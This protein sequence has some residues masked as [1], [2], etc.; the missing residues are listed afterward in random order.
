MALE[1]KALKSTG[2][3]SLLICLILIIGAVLRFYNY[4]DIPFTHDEFSAV[5]RTQFNSFHDLISKGVLVDTHPAGVQVFLY[6]WVKLFGIS[7]PLVKLP[8]TLFSL[9]SVYLLYA[10]GR[11]WFSSTAGLIASSF[12]AFLQYPVM[13]GQIARPYASGLFLVLLMVWFW[14]NLMLSPGKRFYLNLAGYILSSALCAY[15]HHFSLLFVGVA[16]LTGVFII[17]RN[18]RKAFILSWV[19]IFLLYSPHLTIFF[20]QLKQG[21]IG[22]WLSRPRPDFIFDYLA[23]AFQFSWY[24]LAL[25][26]LLVILALVWRPKARPRNDRMVLVS[27]IWFFVPLL[28]GF[29]YSFYINP[30][31][32]YSVLLFSFPFL[33]L[34]M[35]FYADAGKTW[36]KC[37]LVALTA[38]V[39]IPSLIM[40][41]RHYSIFYKS[42]YR[43]ILVESKN[44][45]EKLGR[46]NCF[47]LIDSHRRFTDYYL[48]KPGMERFTVNYIHDIF[49]PPVLESILDSC[50]S[51]YFVYGC[52]S[53]SAWEDYAMIHS[54]YPFVLS[55]TYFNEGDVYVFSKDSAGARADYYFSSYADFD[56]NSTGWENFRTARTWFTGVD[57]QTQVYCMDSGLQ[58]SP[59]FR[60]PLR[61]ISRHK[62]DIVDLCAEVATFDGFSEAYLQLGIYQDSEL[63][64]L[65][66]AIIKSMQPGEYRRIFCSCRL[67]DIEWRHH[68]LD[69]QGFIWNPKK[70][71]LLIRAISFRI[72]H[73]NPVLYGLYR[74]I[75]KEKR[76]S[77]PTMKN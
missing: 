48:E 69:V 57:L 50:K 47:I 35:F 14:T 37:I 21:G 40:E 22:G 42:Q 52:I 32:Q 51:R 75:E 31:L 1:M 62:N 67:A 7:E 8:F 58:F 30:V 65:H 68:S 19:A 5:F 36:Q 4:G 76:I 44:D 45:A 39:V 27:F 16:G 59:I 41:R 2:T 18:N 24:I 29:L 15:N 23:Y 10:I 13:Y 26:V 17:N 74:K 61:D 54:Q 71:D 63:L 66:S 56:S 70:Q 11:K 6:Y 72:R 28:A 43:E 3:D 64:S 33:L 60:G 73:G 55:H 20:S 38:L 53:N 12:L 9:A 34:L 49:D 77:L 25:L 46:S